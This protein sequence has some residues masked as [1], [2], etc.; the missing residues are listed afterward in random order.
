MSGVNENSDIRV[1]PACVCDNVCTLV[2]SGGGDADVLTVI[3]RG[4]GI[5]LGQL[6]LLIESLIN[7]LLLIY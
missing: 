1:N 4:T 6:V 5:V 2:T 7:I 3:E